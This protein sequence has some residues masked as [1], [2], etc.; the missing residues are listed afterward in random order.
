MYRGCVFKSPGISAQKEDVIYSRGAFHFTLE[1]LLLLNK[2]VHEDCTEIL[3]LG[4]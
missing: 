2:Q 4:E 1:A 3:R